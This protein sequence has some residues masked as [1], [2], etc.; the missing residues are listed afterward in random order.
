MVVS[1]ISFRRRAE[2]VRLASSAMYYIRT[3][4]NQDGW[5]EL[6]YFSG[7]V[8][9]H[10]VFASSASMKSQESLHRAVS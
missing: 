9:H 2:Y 8:A 10:V 6:T 3:M 1:K 5:C 4:V 7:N